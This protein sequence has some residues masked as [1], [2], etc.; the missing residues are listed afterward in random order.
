MNYN[1]PITE[2]DAMILG[3]GNA[4]TMAGIPAKGKNPD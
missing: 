2:T 3:G 4:G 1:Y